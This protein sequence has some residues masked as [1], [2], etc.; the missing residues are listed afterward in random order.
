MSNKISKA[1][2]ENVLRTMEFYKRTDG[3]IDQ[4]GKGPLMFFDSQP[5]DYVG[6]YVTK[7]QVKENILNYDSNIKNT[8][9][10]I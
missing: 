7:E 10:K 1:H 3:Y 8:N 2:W 4:E 6:M 9:K 5:N